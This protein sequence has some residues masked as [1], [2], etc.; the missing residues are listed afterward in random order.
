MILLCNTSP[1]C[2]CSAEI[3]NL[4][5]GSWSHKFF[6]P[7][8]VEISVKDSG[9]ESWT[10]SAPTSE[11][12]LLVRY[13]SHTKLSQGFHNFLS[14][15]QM[16]LNWSYSAMVKILCINNITHYQHCALY[17]TPRVGWNKKWSDA[18]ITVLHNIHDQSSPFTASQNVLQFYLH[19]I[20]IMLIY[21]LPSC[22]RSVYL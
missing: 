7:A 16:S 9:Y 1:E 22:F 2:Q 5:Q 17:R 3:A 6:C 20:H 4:H 14:Y 15:Q 12:L 13:L 18:I 11:G 8:V 19:I 21:N 10:G